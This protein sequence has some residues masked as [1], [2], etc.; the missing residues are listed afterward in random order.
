MT[1]NS[2]FSDLLTRTEV[3]EGELKQVIKDELLSLNIVRDVSAGFPDGDLLTIP[4]IGDARIDNYVEDTEVTLRPMD[5][6]EF[7][8]SIDEYVSSGTYITYK[9]MQD[10]YYKEQLMSSFVP[11]Q[12]RAIMEDYESKLF[13]KA[14]VVLSAA[15]ANLQAPI[16]GAN[17]R[18]AG[19]G[20][21]GVIE[22]ADFAYAKYA[23]RKAHMPLNNLIA[24][25]PPEVG[26]TLET[27]TSIVDVSNNKSWEGVI[28]S[29]LTSGM[30]FLK[31][32]YGFDVYES[33]YL[34]VSGTIVPGMSALPDRVGAA[35]I[36]FT[37][38]DGRACH[39]FSAAPG[40][41]MPF[42]G[43]WRQ[44][45]LVSS[46]DV[47]RKQRMETFTTA[48]WAAKLYRPENMVICH[49]NIALA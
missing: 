45:P 34:P 22:L 12:Q 3:W 44:E 19:G 5:T 15:G 37:S 13:T 30:R 25:V 26:F 29:G 10:V 40:D 35:A 4:S 16:N 33:N 20:A 32:I 8:F 1:T 46:V 42:V 18:Y 9:N 14:E 7:Q 24:I 41:T 39:F 17:H 48:R 23:L 2:A 47:P 28:E 21:A 43:A 31:N 11:K 6:G 49:T 36:D 38:V 27:L